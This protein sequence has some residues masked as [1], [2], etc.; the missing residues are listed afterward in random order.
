MC[1]R[2]RRT[3]QATSAPESSFSHPALARA[4]ELRREGNLLCTKRSWADACD[5]YELGLQQPLEELSQ[6][7]EVAKEARD[8]RKVLLL[9]LAIANLHQGSVYRNIAD[10]GLVAFAKDWEKCMHGAIKASDAVLVLDPACDKAYLRRGTA[11]NELALY[12]E[13][14]G[15]EFVNMAREDLEKASEL[16]PD[17]TA[18]KTQ[19]RLRSTD[20]KRRSEIR[21]FIQQDAVSSRSHRP[22]ISAQ[23]IL[24]SEGGEE[25][26][27]RTTLDLRSGRCIALFAEDESETAKVAQILS[28]E[29]LPTCGRVVH[30]G[31]L[32]ATPGRATSFAAWLIA[33]SVSSAIY[34]T[35]FLGYDPW[36]WIFS[37]SNKLD[38]LLQ[39]CILGISIL[40]L[41]LIKLYVDRE[42]KQRHSVLHVGPNNYER[43]LP[44]KTIG[45]ALAAALPKKLS[46]EERRHRA[47]LMLKASGSADWKEVPYTQLGVEQKELSHLLV[48]LARSPDVLVYETASCDSGPRQLRLLHMLRRMKEEIGTSV[49]FITRNLSH[50]QL[51]AD[52][53]GY[54]A[55][56][57]LRE[58]GPTTDVLKSPKHPETSKY[59]SEYQGKC[60]IHEKLD[61][62]VDAFSALET[63]PCITAAWLPESG[64]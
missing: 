22:V 6:D 38:A 35:A 30:H 16:L 56:G 12:L 48:A 11:R 19:L 39:Y 10:N 24:W 34:A 53:I 9:N 50:A 45:S 8:L 63:D 5:S 7:S 41:F 33:I 59:L 21:P 20:D 17:S 1:S 43:D 37:T 42:K 61:A 28:G 23:H 40:L 51:V 62:Q 26:Q 2:C 15:D 13:E 36:H 57:V 46:V 27:H 18:V 32:P 25:M 3:R 47:E 54:I 58:L 31:V 52:S 49:V 44:E 14:G 60:R 4:D 64:R 55:R 29:L